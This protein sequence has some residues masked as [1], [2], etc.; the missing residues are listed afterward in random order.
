ME[1]HMHRVDIIKFQFYSK[2]Y[3]QNYRKIR[4]SFLKGFIMVIM[5]NRKVMYE[6]IVSR[7]T[8]MLC[9][10]AQKCYNRPS[11]EI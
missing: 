4:I 2:F 9:R 7:V 3:Y 11:L 10:S 1:D 5:Y 8:N 6:Y